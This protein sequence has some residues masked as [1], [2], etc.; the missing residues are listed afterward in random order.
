MTDADRYGV[1]YRTAGSSSWITRAA[2]N[3]HKVLNSLQPVDY[4][5]QLRSRCPSGWTSWS[6]TRTFTLDTGGGNGGG[7][8]SGE[9]EVRIVITLDDY[10]S[11]TTWELYDDQNNLVTKGGPYAD[12]IAGTRK[13]KRAQLPDGCYELDIYDS[14]GDGICCDYGNGQMQIYDG[15]SIIA[16]SDGQFGTYE[17]VQFCVEDGVG[18]LIKQ[19]RD[20]KVEGKA[21][22]M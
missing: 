19:E 18:R 9:T 15:S 14:F 20:E 7:G 5:Y 3:S 12:G 4:E 17:L 22:K 6:D 21:R 13:G 10:G 8:G 11:E 1:R 2:R 16:S